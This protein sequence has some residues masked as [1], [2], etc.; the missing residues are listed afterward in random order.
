MEGEISE[1]ASLVE[2]LESE[3]QQLRKAMD[4]TKNRE[5]KLAREVQ[6]VYI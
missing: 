4:Q 1:K 2:Q 6:E 3:L 5:Q